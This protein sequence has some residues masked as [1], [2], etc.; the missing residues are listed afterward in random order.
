LHRRF[1]RFNLALVLVAGIAAAALCSASSGSAAG[2]A[3]GGDKQLAMLRQKIAHVIVIYQENWSFDG[4]YSKFPGANGANGVGTSQLQCPAGGTSYAPM[5]NLPPALS[6]AGRPT[7][8]WPCGWQGLSGGFQDPNIPMGM[9]MKPYDL[10][11]YDTPLML[12]G[13]MW[14]IFWH[15]QLQIDNGTLEPSVLPMGKFAAYSSNPGLTF[16]YYDAT[17]MPEGRL[18][19]RYTLMDNFF[20]SA[21][22]GSFLNHFWL[23]CACT[24]KWNQP[25]PKNAPV[26]VSSWNPATHTLND[27]NLTTMPRPGLDGSP[28]YVVN[29]SFTANAPHPPPIPA[30]QLVA[31]IPATEKTIGDLLTDHQPAISWKWYSG[32]WDL[33]LKDPAAAG[34]CTFPSAN[35]PHP[36]QEGPCFQFHHQP[37]AY[38]QRWGTDGSPEKAAHLQDERNFLADVKSGHL[39]AVSF[40]KPVGVDNEH[41]VYASLVQ[42]QR[43]VAELVDAVCK[44]PYWKD[45]VIIITYDENGGRWDHVTPPKVD[46]WGPG[47][48]VP[49]ILVSPYVRAHHVDHAQAETNS[50]LTLIEKRWGLPN[51][52]SHDAT[53]NP[54]LEAFDFTQT[55]LACNAS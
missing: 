21:F 29:T 6:V 49:T 30:D 8:P 52:G 10:T 34:K 51:L 25:L 24:P 43:H 55:P 46:Q 42:G 17:N 28:L 23:I 31:P 33:A 13:D 4:L 19:R 54:M 44:S 9:P 12:T 5:P 20:H 26:F 3:T 38:F 50:I 35:D 45:T 14:H 2:P 39:P 36:V 37:F 40:V 53:A 1:R 22:G 41:P 18:A 48:R 11:Q 32:H 27:S 15:E 16:S 47:T 7:G